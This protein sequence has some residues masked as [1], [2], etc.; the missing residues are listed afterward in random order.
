MRASRHHFHVIIH[1]YMTG[2]G[3]A[4]DIHLGAFATKEEAAL[5]YDDSIRL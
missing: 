2:V 1:L 4:T 3:R 5:A